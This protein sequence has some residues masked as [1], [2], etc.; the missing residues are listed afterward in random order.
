MVLCRLSRLRDFV[1]CLSGRWIPRAGEKMTAIS[2]DIPTRRC[3]CK[4][5]SDMFFAVWNY[6]AIIARY[7][8]KVAVK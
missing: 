4:R 3:C 5:I 7:T 8:V 2:V 6:L 1:V